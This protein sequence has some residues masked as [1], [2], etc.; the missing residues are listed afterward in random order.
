MKLNPV[1]RKRLNRF[2]KLR[3]ASWSLVLL[4][5]LYG[6]SLG[7]EL[8]S[9]DRPL[10]ARYQ[11]ETYF[12]VFKFYPADIFLGNGIQTRPDYKALERSAEFADAGGSMTWPP[13]PYGPYEI[14]DTHSIALPDEV[15]LSLQP[16]P[17]VGTIN[18][19][20]EF[21]ISRAA[22]AGW[23]FGVAD[24][25][26][27]D[28]PLLETWPLPAELQDAV[29]QRF[30]NAEQPAIS[31]IV[32][33]AD[34]QSAEV[35]LSTYKPRSRAPRSVRLTLREPEGAS[36][37]E[38]FVFARDLRILSQSSEMWAGLPEDIR[39]QLLAT[40]TE[41]FERPV[42]PQS[43]T[44]GEIEYNVGL[45]KADLQ[46]PFPP[47]PGHA[48]GVDSS[49]RDVF[50]RVLYGL[51][52]SLTFG[53]LLVIVSMV[54]GIA[55]GAVQGYWGGRVD[56]TGQR[57]IEVWSALPF[58]YIMILMG[59]VFG[60]G[61]MLLLVCYGF[62]N[63]I[64]ISYYMRAEFLRLRGQ[65]FVDAARCLGLPTHRI[66][67]RH[68]LPNALVPVV[69]FF[70]FSLV[71]AIG[72]LTALDYLGF[73]LPPPTPS[74]GELLSQASEFKH[75]WWLVLYP[76]VALFVVMLLGVFVGEGVRAAY[77]PK[78]RIHLE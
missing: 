78:P 16:A 3:R 51:R 62:F 73:G 4:V 20:A 48:L 1:T 23:F 60:R 6:I 37:A 65:A 21:T 19:D 44:I 53:L 69:T 59:S 31:M 46:F 77:D 18:V 50:S 40:V 68:I 63:W 55:A 5:L 39:E 70:P 26:T 22:S 52:T 74:W 36:A 25:A 72:V 28:L 64:G 15:T 61:F 32:A 71:G 27:R 2:L 38:I 29:H 43:I 45:A 9:N 57:I 56:I 41:R 13:I 76:S 8:L 75:A 49:G 67:F 58:L 66:I 54:L 14:L 33:R 7:S 42:E 35:S 11:G 10:I 17:R 12:P 34:G 24:S 30:A 47:T